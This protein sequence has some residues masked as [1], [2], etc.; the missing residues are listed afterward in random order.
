MKEIVRMLKALG[1]ESR[2]RILKMLESRT[3]CVCEIAAVLGLAQSTVSRHLKMLEDSGL[4][5]RTKNGLW[6]EYSLVSPGSGTPAGSLLGLFRNTMTD[7]PIV[8]EDRRKAI[9]VDRE[10]VCGRE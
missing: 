2:V 10:V 7:D 8:L 3:L 9:H 5:Y 4:V 1:D 6:V